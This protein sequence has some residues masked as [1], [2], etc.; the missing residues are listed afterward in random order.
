M[1]EGSTVPPSARLRVRLGLGCAAAL[2]WLVAGLLACGR[3]RADAPRIPAIQAEDA[4]AAPTTASPDAGK[5]ALPADQDPSVY[6]PGRPRLDLTLPDAFQ[7]AGRTADGALFRFQGVPDV[8][9]HVAVKREKTDALPNTK[10]LLASMLTQVRAA[11]VEDVS[12]RITK[13]GEALVA[14]SGVVHVKGRDMFTRHW[15][16]ASPDPKGGVLRADVVLGIPALWRKQ[17]ATANVIGEIDQ[18]FDQAA[19]RA[20]S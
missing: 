20:G 11:G 19:L 18:R 12:S 1:R 8:Q 15:V 5:S 10:E 13:K 4:Q 9:V 14:W 17:K 7:P 2:L 3:G 16:L 6:V